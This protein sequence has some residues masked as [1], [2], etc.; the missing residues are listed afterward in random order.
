MSREF[1]ASR[2]VQ[3]PEHVTVLPGGLPAGF[4]AAGIAAGLKN[5]IDMIAA[6]TP[7]QYELVVSQVLQDPNS[8]YRARG[9]SSQ[10]G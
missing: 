6:A 8:V 7:E 5:P 4:R 1:F 3:R 2:W 10:E 9:P